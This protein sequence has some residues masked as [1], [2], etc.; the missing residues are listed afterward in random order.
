MNKKDKIKETAKYIKI[1]MGLIDE[2][3]R[4]IWVEIE[5]KDDEYKR[6]LRTVILKI[7]TIEHGC[8]DVLKCTNRI[9]QLLDEDEKNKKGLKIF[10]VDKGIEYEKIGEDVPK[11][12][13][14]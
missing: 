9:L 13:R 1:A 2:E 7:M 5:N 4:K 3:I 6:M 8:K 12:A 11:A 14:A 10:L